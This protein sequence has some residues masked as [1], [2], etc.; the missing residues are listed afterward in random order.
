[1]FGVVRRPDLKERLVEAYA[2]VPGMDKYVRGLSGG[3]MVPVV[4]TASGGGRSWAPGE[5]YFKS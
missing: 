5:L 4:E 1:M 2:G 3:G